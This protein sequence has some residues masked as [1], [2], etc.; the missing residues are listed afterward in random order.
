VIRLLVADDQAPVLAGL[1]MLLG[2]EPDIDIVGEAVDGADLVAL[3]RSRRPDV[4]LTDIRMP[5]MD[6]LAAIRRLTALEPAPAVIALTTF[7]TDEYLFGAL[8]AGA[9]GFLLKDGD[10]ALFA[11]AVRTAHAGGGLIDPQVTPR[12]V[13][14]FALTSPR[15]PGR[16]LAGLTARET[17]VLR[18]LGFGHTNAHIAELLAIS[19]GT[20]KVHV[21]RVLA[22]LRLESRVHAALYA[23]RHGLLTWADGGPPG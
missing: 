21:E 18:C 4:V 17:E 5:R 10:E 11:R 15:P 2:G 9:V 3:A 12:L 8:Q 14:Q 7:D 13:R 6:G 20:V 22:K 16:E 23:Y 1:R 19:P